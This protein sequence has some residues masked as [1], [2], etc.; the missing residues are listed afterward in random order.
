M[1]FGNYTETEQYR[2]SGEVENPFNFEFDHTECSFLFEHPNFIGNHHKIRLIKNPENDNILIDFRNTAGYSNLTYKKYQILRNDLLHFLSFINGGQIKLRKELLGEVLTIKSTNNGF[3]A[4]TV[5]VYSFKRISVFYCNNYL[6]IDKHHS[7]TNEIFHNV[8]FHGFNKF[9]HL[10]KCFDFSELI[11][12][13]N[14]TNDIGLD[15]G[16]FILITALE[17]ISKNYSKDNPNKSKYLIEDDFFK[18]NIK[19]ELKNIF[20]RH[21]QEIVSSNKTAWNIFNSK[22]GNLNRRNNSETS[23]KLYE[24]LNY[25]N[26]KISKSVV[27]LVEKER[28]SAVHEGVI[29]LNDTEKIKNYWKLDHI[30]RDIILN[31]IEYKGSRKRKYDYEKE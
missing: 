8:F 3:D 16:Y 23:Q 7:Y 25:A 14:S 13:L 24:L 19:P 11:L 4:Q 31:L 12:S 30:L 20:N 1:H 28:N 6:Q 5:I 27:K 10:N 15:E 9:Y 26:I 29:G 18:D 22:I 2:K 21:K 17:R